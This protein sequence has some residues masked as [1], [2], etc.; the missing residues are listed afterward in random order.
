MPITARSYLGILVLGLGTLVGPLDSA[1]NIAFPY[2]TNAFGLPLTDIRWVIVSYVLTYSSLMLIFGKL[3]DLFGHRLIFAAGLLFSAVTF[4]LCAT[5]SE[6]S[7]LLAFRIAQGVG[8]SL[9]LSCGPAIA[10]SLF[11]E[12]HR[13]RALGIY[14]MLF[15]IGG[16]LGPLIGGIIVE[17]WGWPAVFWFRMPISIIALIFVFILPAP[18][19]QKEREPFDT[20]SAA[21]LA[22]AV[23]ALLLT[24]TQLQH[25]GD[26]P[27]QFAG[28]VIITGVAA[29]LYHRRSQHQ[30]SPVIR[31]SIFRSL[32]FAILNLS[33]IA[34][35]LTGFAILLLVPYYLA[36][37]SSFTV[38]L[39]GFVLALSAIAT[40]LASPAGGWLIGRFAPNRMAF[41]GI[42]LV[43][44][45]AILI[46]M[47]DDTPGIW[48]MSAPLIV[49][50]LGIGLFQVAYLSAVT[51]TLPASERGVAGSLALLT[52]TIGVVCSAS[53]LTWTLSTF[54]MHHAGRGLNAD[55]SFLAAFQSTFITV[56]TCLLVFLFATCAR[57]SIWFGRQNEGTKI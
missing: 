48:A 12:Q 31:I 3:G 29:L 46:G 41:S 2:I 17:I 38:G 32:P 24:V 45:S 18:P 54:S 52:R 49:S 28:L 5:A 20:I 37:V 57:P 55:A 16:V 44:L 51:G 21:L 15:G 36:K 40:M 50:G 35:N 42:V 47:W 53:F 23:S 9:V 1:V 13:S 39:G 34:V 33:G 56:G 7:W 8:A 6:F 19:R 10:T 30:T 25:A 11:P 14:L 4:A 26:T 22:I 43:G 27:L